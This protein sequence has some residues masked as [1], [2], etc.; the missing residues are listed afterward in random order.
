MHSPPYGRLFLWL[1]QRVLEPTA[2]NVNWLQLAIEFTPNDYAS[3]PIRSVAVAPTHRRLFRSLGPGFPSPK[4][5]DM[6]H[7]TP[8]GG[9]TVH[10]RTLGMPMCRR[11]TCL[12][13]RM[14]ELALLAALCVIVAQA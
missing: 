9:C 14:P 4:C 13:R 1:S 8:R 3:I 6:G 11:Y 10:H 12:V 5:M 2:V 7:N